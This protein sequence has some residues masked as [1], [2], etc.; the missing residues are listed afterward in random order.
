MRNLIAGALIVSALVAA[1]RRGVTSGGGPDVLNT[2]GIERSGA[3]TTLF[4]GVTLKGWN[5]DPA[6]FFRVLLSDTASR[7]DNLRQ[8]RR[9]VDRELFDEFLSLGESD[10]FPHTTFRS[11]S[12]QDELKDPQWE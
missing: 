4:D 6:I 9:R 11:Q 1:D 2:A 8:I 3:G 5:G 7:P 10:Y 12:E